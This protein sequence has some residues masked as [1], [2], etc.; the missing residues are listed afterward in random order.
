MRHGLCRPPRPRYEPGMSA[1]HHLLLV[2]LGVLFLVDLAVL[3]PLFV[4]V[5]VVAHLRRR[6]GLQPQAL[7]QGLDAH[8]HPGQPEVHVLAE[9]V[10]GAAGLLQLVLEHVEVA[11]HGADHLAHLVQVLQLGGLLLAAV[12]DD[13]LQLLDAAGALLLDALQLR[14]AGVA[15]RHLPLQA[16]R[17]AD[18]ALLDHQH[19][20]GGDHGTAVH[21]FRPHL[22]HQHPLVARHRTDA[23]FLRPT[24]PEA[25]PP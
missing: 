19:P 16:A 25:S 7:L 23:P 3:V 21:A 10:A 20:R 4:L 15:Q 9:V 2:G 14:H 8:L 17:V 22:T 18:A 24:G 5:L 13:L 6:R 12:A 11:A 1:R